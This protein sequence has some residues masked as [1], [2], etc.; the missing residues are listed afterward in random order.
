MTVPRATEK[1]PLVIE[2]APVTAEAESQSLIRSR[3]M[4]HEMLLPSPVG[5]AG[6]EVTVA[7]LGLGS[8][9]P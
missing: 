2:L 3:N 4:L 8:D 9:P 5:T 7:R 6:S 1:T